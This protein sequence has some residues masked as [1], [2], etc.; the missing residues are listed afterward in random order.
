[1]KAL[2]LIKNNP[3]IAGGVV[4]AVV[5]GLWLVTRGAKGMGQDIGGGAVNLIFGTATGA[6]NAVTDNLLDPNVNPFY[7][8]GT[9]LGG[10]LFDMTH[11]AGK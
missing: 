1:M 3:V 8:A 7:D 2:N 6:K 10:W 4:V 5:A 11:G 9:S